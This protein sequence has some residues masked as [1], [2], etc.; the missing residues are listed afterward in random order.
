MDEIQK[1][2]SILM[3]RKFAQKENISRIREREYY[4][5][6]NALYNNFVSINDST[7]YFNI[8]LAQ[9]ALQLRNSFSK[10]SIIEKR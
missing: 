6:V 7:S 10:L 4:Y 8:L 9:N 2:C 3:H 5:E 1:T